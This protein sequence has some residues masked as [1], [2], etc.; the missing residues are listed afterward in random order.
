MK[1]LLASI[2]TTFAMVA[3]ALSVAAA[4]SHA[5]DYEPTIATYCV[6]NTGEAEAR[7]IVFDFRIATNGFGSPTADVK[8]T[9]VNRWGKVVKRTSRTY[10]GA[11]ERWILGD[12]NSGMYRL[13][14]HADPHEDRFYACGVGTGVYVKR[15]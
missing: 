6:V 12:L 2:L 11:R 4:P 9:L 3:T 13:R 15:P 1:K 5:A 8:I 10:D 7:R 14:I